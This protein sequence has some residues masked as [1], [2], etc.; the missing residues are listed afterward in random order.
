LIKYHSRPTHP[1]T[2]HPKKTQNY[3]STFEHF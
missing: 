1:Q 2:P 3:L